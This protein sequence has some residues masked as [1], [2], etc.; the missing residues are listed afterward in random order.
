MEAIKQYEYKGYTIEI[1]YDEW[2]ES[3]REW[4]NLGTMATFSSR[5]DIGDAHNFT[6]AGELIN[7]INDNEDNLYYLPVYIYDHGGI[8][9]STS[10]F[11]DRW[12]S[13]QIGFIYMTKEKAKEE[14]ITEYEALD[15]LDREVKTM[16]DF[17]R[18]NVYGYKVFNDEGEELDS[19][20]GY[21]GRIEDC[22][23]AAESVVDYYD[24][25]LPKQYELTFA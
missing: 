17:V 5:Y 13:G 6:N 24:R 4:D 7:Y 19:C 9:L 10:P 11:G 23:E 8:A 25:T 12:D 16:D 14:G 20:W 3:P 1:H 21:I 18:G 15:R 2:G 22:E